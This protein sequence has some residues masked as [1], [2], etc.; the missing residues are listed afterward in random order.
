MGENGVWGLSVW[1]LILT[2]EKHNLSYSFHC[3][4]WHIF[5][6]RGEWKIDLLPFIDM[7]IDFD[8]KTTVLMK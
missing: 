2:E 8:V 4:F 6:R 7:L 5:T 3:M 1:N